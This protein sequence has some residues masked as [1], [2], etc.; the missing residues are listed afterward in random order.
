MT[1]TRCANGTR[2]NKKTGECVK[3]HLLKKR[4]ANGT[5]RNKKTGECVKKHLSN[6]KKGMNKK[7]PLDNDKFQDWERDIFYDIE[8]RF[9]YNSAVKLTAADFEGLGVNDDDEQHI[10]DAI[11]LFTGPRDIKWKKAEDFVYKMYK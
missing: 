8:N 9:K 5:H 10:R 7:S 2:R 11:Q 4:C 6:G 3:K 1:R